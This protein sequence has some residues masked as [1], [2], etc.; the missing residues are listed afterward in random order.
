MKIAIICSYDFSIAWS[1]EILV[2]KLLLDNE[3]TVISD[4]HDGYKYGHYLKI[5]KQWGVRH[6]YVKIYRFISPFQ[7]LK[8][9][10]SLYRILHNEH[11]DM[12]INIATKPN[13]YGS[14]AARWTNVEKIVCFGWGLGLVFAKTK[15]I[16]S[17]VLKY[18]TSTLYRYAFKVSHKVWFTNKNDRDYFI[19]KKMIDSDKTILTPGFVNTDQ[20]S[21]SSV[22]KNISTNLRHEL[23]Y[24]DSDKIVLMV[25]RM[26][27]A[28]GVEQFCQA[29]DRLRNDY[30]HVRFL[31]VGPK[32]TG[33]PDSVPVSYIN[34][35]EKYENFAWLGYRIDMKELYSISYLAVFPSYY[36]EGGWPRGVT[37][38]MAM[39]KPVIT[40]DSEHCSGAVDDGVSGLLVPVKDAVSLAK[41]IEKI[42]NDEKLASGFGLKS[43]EKAV[44]ELDEE[45]IMNQLI[46]AII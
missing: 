37:E 40:T 33:S 2:K 36:R 24:A 29:S 34:G 20:Y 22:P 41:A 26:S 19:S 31:L 15:N 7:D 1:L 43:R 39:G 6:K 18:I 4:I 5:M 16:R 35:Y 12:V 17:V 14:I 3:V 21:P 28:K 45:L 23:G 30:P 42:V 32:D 25:A 9:L 46:K 13:I 27:W 44:K 38:P 8:Y 10:F 11:F